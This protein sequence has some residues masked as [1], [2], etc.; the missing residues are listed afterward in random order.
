MQDDDNMR[1]LDWLARALELFQS[2]PTMA[3]LGGRA[4]RL[5]TGEKGEVKG[6]R[7][8][9]PGYTRGPL[10]QNDG[11]KYGLPP[12]LKLQKVSL[13]FTA[14]ISFSANGKQL[15]IVT[16]RISGGR[17]LTGPFRDARRFPSTR[18]PPVPGATRTPRVFGIF[19][20]P[21]RSLSH[22]A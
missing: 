19:P 8:N 17:S 9:I 21:F 10:W 1:A 5:D 20:H 7:L 6:P 22:R 12:Y 18:L 16:L 3:L 15:R 11:P 14:S 4:G 13:N 2:H